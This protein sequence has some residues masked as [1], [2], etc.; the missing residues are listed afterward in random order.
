MDFGGTLFCHV[1]SPTSRLEISELIDEASPYGGVLS[2]FN[3]R[4][5]TA[6]DVIGN[7]VPMTSSP[8]DYCDVPNDDLSPLEPQSRVTPPPT[9]M[10]PTPLPAV[11]PL[12]PPCRVCGEKASGFHYGANTCEACKVRK[13]LHVKWSQLQLSGVGFNY[14]FI[15]PANSIQHHLTIIKNYY[16]SNFEFEMDMIPGLAII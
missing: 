13:S 1:A 12:L 14:D 10:R 15:F 11:T 7:D 5:W 6:C 4:M 3:S 2:P 16:I 9:S 8:S